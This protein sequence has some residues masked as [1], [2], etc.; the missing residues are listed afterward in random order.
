[1]IPLK[2]KRLLALGLL[3]LACVLV[4]ESCNEAVCGPLVSKCM[5]I[6]CCDCEMA[7][8]KNCTCCRECQICLSKL[9]TECCS[10]VGLCPP[11]DIGDE[12]ERSSSVEDLKDPIPALFDVLT[13]QEDIHQRWTTFTYAVD[14]DKLFSH[15]SSTNKQEMKVKIIKDGEDKINSV[16]ETAH[17]KPKSGIQNCT[18]AFFSD[19]MPIGKCKASCKSMGANKYRWF[20]E[21]GCCQCIGSTCFDYGLSEPKC[22]RCPEQTET[23]FGDQPYSWAENVKPMYQ[24]DAVFDTV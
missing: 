23:M 14:L 9:Y 20:H 17:G 15:G 12:L 6:K 7:D 2:S 8:L 18:V 22:L 16:E 19:C 21:Y 3:F 10:C 24:S 11:P 4:V 13:E 5:L 1:M